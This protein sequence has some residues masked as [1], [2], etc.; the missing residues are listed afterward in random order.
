MNCSQAA[1]VQ[2]VFR[3]IGRC[4]YESSSLSLIQGPPGRG[5]STAIGLIIGSLLHHTE[6][7]HVKRTQRHYLELQHDVWRRCNENNG[8]R[9]LV[10]SPSNTAN[11]LVRACIIDSMIEDMAGGMLEPQCVRLCFRSARSPNSENVNDC[12]AIRFERIVRPNS[13]SG[14]VSKKSKQLAKRESTVIFSTTAMAVGNAFR[15][16]VAAFDIVII[17]E[18]SQG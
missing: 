17:D 13:Q 2:N 12:K 18:C 10:Q 6:V 8:V 16:L 14:S 3:N 4:N 7:G 1:A 11:D 5:K 15:D 9:I